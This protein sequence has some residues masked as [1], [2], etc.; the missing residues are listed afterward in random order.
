MIT[1]RSGT[2]A[3]LSKLS[4]FARR[5][6]LVQLTYRTALIS[7]W[8]NILAQAVIFAY[9]SKLISPSS[10]PQYGN[11]QT[12]YIAFVSVGLT[13]SVFLQVGVGQISTAIRSEQL[14][15]TLEAL[16][17]TPTQSA[18]LLLGT[19]VYDLFYVPIRTAL[20]L[21]VVA[22]WTGVTF[23]TS[24]MLPA[25][26]ILVAFTPFVWGL[27]AAVAAATLTFKRAAAG[28]GIVTF[29]LT[30]SS[31]T[32]FPLTLF[33]S[34]VQTLA[35]ANPVAVALNGM[36]SCLLGGEGWSDALPAIA[37]L[38]VCSAVT[39]AAGLL[40]FRIALRR[41]ARLGTVALY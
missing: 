2:W 32:Y 37:F 3:E 11:E 17:V 14:M 10:L 33:P 13:V 21:A 34:W 15:G 19:V 18:T 29:L 16:L 39:L 28:I 23:A 24:G 27:G 22:L 31:G 40:A 9:V 41:E 26:A 35:K 36:R 20:F 8:I 12:S 5:D 30:I 4:A 7:D 6:L 25:A 1:A 38:L